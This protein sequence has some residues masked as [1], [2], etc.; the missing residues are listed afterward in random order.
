MGRPL[1]V[2]MQSIQ[3]K[4]IIIISVLNLSFWGGG[5]GGFKLSVKSPEHLYM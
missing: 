4:I 1:P 3:V 2:L 5:G